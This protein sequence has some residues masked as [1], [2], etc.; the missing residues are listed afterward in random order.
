M[1]KPLAF[2]LISVINITLVIADDFSASEKFQPFVGKFRAKAC[3][4]YKKGALVDIRYD[5]SIMTR[6]D[7]PNKWVEGLIITSDYYPFPGYD[8]TPIRHQ[9]IYHIH[10][11]Q[12]TRGFYKTFFTIDLDKV[13]FKITEEMERGRTPLIRS[14]MEIVKKGQNKM[15]FT[16]F[17]T[18]SFGCLLTAISEREYESELTK[19][20]DATSGDYQ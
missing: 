3:S 2:C 14:Y 1:M 19:I 15:L 4:E 5:E 18:S 17:R 16:N 11:W 20:G 9:R 8:G 6:Y 13:F 10:G 12:Q 7:V